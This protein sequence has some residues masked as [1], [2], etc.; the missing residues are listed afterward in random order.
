MSLQV[1]HNLLLMGDTSTWQLSYQGGF[2]GL[3]GNIVSNRLPVLLAVL[4][5]D[6][7]F[8]LGALA[9]TAFEAEVAALTILQRMCAGSRADGYTT[10]AACSSQRE[11]AQAAGLDL[12]TL[13]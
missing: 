1:A 4:T 3:L 2:T 13:L 9:L 11:I 6:L 12:L 7:D 5:I 8:R 10:T